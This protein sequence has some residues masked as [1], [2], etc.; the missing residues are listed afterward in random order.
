MVEPGKSQKQSRTAP[1]PP[2][3][4]LTHPTY[5]PSSDYSFLEIVM[6]MQLTLGGLAEAVTSLKADAKA[7]SEK[8]SKIEGDLH[9]VRADIQAAKVVLGVIGALLTAAIAFA[10]WVAKTYLDYLGTHPH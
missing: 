6:S 4:Q 8:L 10:G 1:I 3:P 2:E 5:A 7:N 9:A